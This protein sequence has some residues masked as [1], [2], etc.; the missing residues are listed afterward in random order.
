MDF[1]YSSPLERSS[2]F[3]VTMSKDF[4]RLQYFSFET[5]FLENKNH[6]QKT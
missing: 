2:W 5:D 3:Y 6:C 4:K 1:Q